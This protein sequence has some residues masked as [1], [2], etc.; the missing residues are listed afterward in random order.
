MDSVLPSQWNQN[1]QGRQGK[2]SALSRQGILSLR[3]SDSDRERVVEV[4]RAAGADGRLTMDEHSERV[5]RAYASR[6]LGELADLTSDLVEDGAAAPV[7]AETGPVLAIFRPGERNGRWVVPASLPVTAVFGE[8]GLDLREALLER[9][10]VTITATAVGGEVSL[11]V[12][13]GVE[14][15]MSGP[16]VLGRRTSRVRTRP[17]PGAPVVHVRCYIL[18][19]KVSVRLPRRRRWF[20]R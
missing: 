14:V 11:I 18:L 10:E 9:R 20:R 17:A 16:A 1:K 4:L 2:P 13:E 3:A 15:R 5:Q 8:A 6:T 19:G 7:R 12:P